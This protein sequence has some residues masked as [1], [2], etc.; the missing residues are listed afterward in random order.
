[1]E[2]ILRPQPHDDRELVAALAEA[3]GLETAD[4]GQQGAADLAHRQTELGDPLAVEEQPLLGLALAP[5]H[6]HVGDARQPLHAAPDV[7]RDAVGAGQIP[8][9][10]LDLDR[11]AAAG[12]EHPVE[13]PQA[14]L[15]LDVDLGA[16]NLPVHRARAPGRPSRCCPCV[17]RSRGS[18]LSSTAALSPRTS[19]DD[20]LDVA[21]RQDAPDLALELVEVGSGD[22]DVGAAGHLELDVDLVRLGPRRQLDRD[23]RPQQQGDDRAARR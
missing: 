7:G 17:R 11:A 14:L 15:R 22:G 18:S 4:V 3:P 21:L 12:A 13:H 9:A 19:V 16:G 6:P 10:Q 23:Q 1:M 5:A 8:A 20:D 2:A